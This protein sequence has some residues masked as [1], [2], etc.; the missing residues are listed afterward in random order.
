MKRFLTFR[1]IGSPNEF[2]II[3]VV[4][5]IVAPP[6][7]CAAALLSL[8][9]DRDWHEP[10]SRVLSVAVGIVLPYAWLSALVRNLRRARNRR[11]IT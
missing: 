11:N 7:I 5:I 9:S 1:G 6:I 4:V 8:P 10:L 2:L 3:N